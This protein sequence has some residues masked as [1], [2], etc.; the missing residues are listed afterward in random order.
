MGA[1]LAMCPQC[2][3]TMPAGARYCPSCGEPVEAGLVAELQQMYAELRQLDSWV[4]AGKGGYTVKALRGEILA[5]YL[6][7]RTPAPA[8]ATAGASAAEAERAEKI[9]AATSSAAAPMAAPTAVDVQAA[10]VAAAPGPVFSWRAFI[11][12]QAI[13]I[14]AY[15]G[16]FLLLVATL[17]FEVGG[18]QVLD[19][20]VKL[21]AVCAV[22]VVF[23][24]LGVA[25]PRVASL[26]T[27]GRA[28]LAVFA[29]M[30][31]LVALAVYRFELQ[32]RGFSP[33]GMLCLAAAY[34]AVIYLSLAWRTRFATYA[35]LGWAAGLVA[36]LAV[37]P[38][39]GV[40]KMWW[41]PEMAVVSLALLTP[42]RLR[43]V[44][45]MAALE[46]PATQLAALT[47][48][49]AGVGIELAGLAVVS[50]AGVVTASTS[51]SLPVAPTVFAWAAVALVPLAALWA[52]TVRDRGLWAG[53][54]EEDSLAGESAAEGP[55]AGSQVRPQSLAGGRQPLARAG[56]EEAHDG[57]NPDGVAA[58]G[59]H[60][61]GIVDVLD[62]LVAAFVAQAAVGVAWWLGADSRGLAWTMAATAL[63]EVAGAG[64]LR[65][66]A[67]ARW[68]LRYGVEG[69][70]VAL[71]AVAPLLV[72]AE[73]APNWPLLATLAAGLIVTVSVA[74]MES[75]PWW[76][77]ASGLYL[78]AGY[79]TLLDAVLPARVIDVGF[80]P[81][82]D[83]HVL[84]ACMAGLALA[85]WLAPLLLGLARG[86]R[87][88]AR[89]LYVVALGD[90]LYTSVLLIGT[91]ALQ[92]TL[93]LAVFAAAALVAARREAA[94][95]TGNLLFAFFGILAVVPY[96]QVDERGVRVALA[97]LAPALVALAVRRGLGRRWAYGAY[98]VG[99]W[100]ALVA[101][102][103]LHDYGVTT[104]SVTFLG[105]SFASWTLLAAA[106]LAMV[107]AYWEDERWAQVAPAGLAMLAAVYVPN[108]VSQV[109]L[110]FVLAAV[111][112]GW[113]FV[114]GPWWGAAWYGGAM[115]TSVVAGVWLLAQ[116]SSVPMWLAFTPLAFG[117]AAYLVAA[118]EREPLATPVAALYA[119]A[120]IWQLPGDNKLVSTLVLTFALVGVGVALRLRFGVRWA[121][122]AYGAAAAGSLFA[123][124]RVTPANPGLVEA[125]LLVFAALSYALAALE[126]EPLAG[127]V[128]T[129]YACGAVVVQPGPQALLPLALA[130]GILAVI[131]GRVAGPRWSWPIYA[132]AAVN[133]AAGAVLA[134][135]DLRF[136]AF[137]L[138]AIAALVYVVAALES[139]PDLLPLAFLVGGLALAA[140]VGALGWLEWQ[141]IVAFA[142]LG[143]VYYLG[144]ALW[145]R[146]PW[147]GERGGAWWTEL[148]LGPAWTGQT[149]D[150]RFVGTQAHY[151]SGLVVAAGV[152]VAAVV[153][154]PDA[155]AVRAAATQAVVVALVSFGGMLAVHA[156]TPHMH[157]LWY[158]AGEI[159]ALAVTWQARWL[160]ADNLQAF[161]LAPGSYQLVVGALLPADT[162]LRRAAGIGQAF[163]LVGSLV[164]LLPTLAQSFLAGPE[165]VYALLLALEALVIAG[166][167]VGTRSRLLVLTGSVFVG[168]AALR[169]G[170]L[171]VTSGVPVAV[172]I[173][174]L[175]LLLM[176]GAT[177]LSLRSRR[178]IDPTA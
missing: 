148:D 178:S 22:Y 169:G 147:L 152:C 156:R 2:G 92:Q 149:R 142:A 64:A 86:G 82:A 135:G 98:A 171:A 174:G 172:V 59:R 150:A 151:W 74:V 139:R 70:A 71:A 57:G 93:I 26:R 65:R 34:G 46:E 68:G 175:A 134:R 104:V 66:L 16:G 101:F 40:D 173:A 9:P 28:Y 53:M 97:A 122:A 88:Y 19:N 153:V 136:E 84:S 170:A 41:L 166:A 76:L 163:S 7:L 27:V 143:W 80:W 120:A 11:A 61:P 118:L 133:A 43:R 146:L 72:W 144:A 127:V 33:Y 110:V 3:K 55:G 129:L 100:A 85:V 130:L 67:A 115:I 109:V 4:N 154:A 29:L 157:A 103:H 58:V 87:R 145:R 168:V 21:A 83:L 37:V 126:R 114:K 89:P 113:R 138:A 107:A 125:L 62:W 90:A 141:R 14:M 137:G 60:I 176:G 96:A 50:Q 52:V 167:G 44:A 132:A 121:L 140:A 10:A 23:G 35:Y 102:R 30:T 73:P 155:F 177:W 13:A 32:Q 69:L 116:E 17:S 45:V 31:P 131:V 158:V 78:T 161:V 112:V 119:V 128:P 91:P 111:G 54:G 63:I 79:Q 162:R 24:A 94:A 75:A 47:S 49:A 39:T 123:L 36:A 5:R 12:E 1:R 18:W 81:Y 6:E 20:T 95:V 42:R 164:L 106:V 38:W 51:S 56:I 99:L 159:L 160:G 77:L 165:W 15:L 117:V 8:M 25:L 48:L 108:L 124:T 105:I